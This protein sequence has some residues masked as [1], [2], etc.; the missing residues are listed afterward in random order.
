MEGGLQTLTS[1]RI[2]LSKT[3]HAVHVLQLKAAQLVWSDVVLD[4]KS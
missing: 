1:L 2:C 3:L 4:M